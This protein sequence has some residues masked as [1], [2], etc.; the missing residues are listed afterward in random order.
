[1]SILTPARTSGPAPEPVDAPP[2][3]GAA[4]LGAAAVA[5]GLLAW[6]GTQHGAQQAVLLALGLGLGAA[7]FHARFGFTSGWRQLV[8]VGHGAG[9]RAHALL[10]GTAATLGLLVLASG[11]GLFGSTPSPVEGSLGLGLLLG[12]FLFGVGMQMGGACASGTLFAV[13]SGQSGILVTLGGFIVGSVLYT[14][15]YG[16]VDD[17]PAWDP[18]LLQDH[19]GFGGAWALTILALV[20]IVVGSKAYQDRRTPPP[21]GRPP[22]ARGWARVVRGSW[23]MLVGAVV[24]GVLAVGVLWVSGGIWGITS[25]FALWG[26]K[27]LQLLGMHPETWAYWQQPNQAAQ[28]AGPVL[29]DKNTL[30][31]LGIIVGAALA[32]AVAGVYSLRHRFRARETTGAFLGGIL[33][34][35]GARLAE[36]CNIGAYLGGITTGSLSGWVW[37]LVALAGT[38]VGLRLRPLFGLAVPRPKDTVC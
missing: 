27:V 18:I 26:A 12:S 14:W 3:Q 17:L 7:L 20:G 8:A 23:P 36:G 4:S 38:W 24:L 29:S 10:L 32:A 37:G 34:G 2:V 30:T 31:N 25:A 1:M 6:V 28:L 11:A 5:V 19:V 22:S 33:L 9:V 21:T 15:Q 16:L 13:G 35:I